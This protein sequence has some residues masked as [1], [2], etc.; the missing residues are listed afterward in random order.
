MYGH[1]EAIYV[2]TRR[3]FDM[4]SLAVAIQDS[5]DVV[6]SSGMVTPL[7][8]AGG[9]DVHVC[10]LRSFDDSS[11]LMWNVADNIRT[12]AATNAVRILQ[13]H[14]ELNRAG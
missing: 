1:S 6:L 4:D 2:R 8:V 5:E 14:V 10:R 13:K 9:D 3:P 11:F 12:G 7:E